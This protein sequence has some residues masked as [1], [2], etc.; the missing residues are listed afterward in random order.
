[1]TIYAVYVC[2]CVCVCVGVCVCESGGECVRECERERERETERE[3]E[4]DYLVTVPDA[5]VALTEAWT[6]PPYNGSCKIPSR[7]IVT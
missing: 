7:T 3:R 4:R 5:I 6:L 2:V 1:M